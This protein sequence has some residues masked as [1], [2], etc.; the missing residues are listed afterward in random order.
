[1]NITDVRIRKINSSG[2][3]R[4]VVSV[5]M[6]NVFVVHEIKIVEGYN[7]LFVAM[8]SRKTPDGAFIDVAHPIDSKT[9]EY[10]QSLVLE[11][12]E[13]MLELEQGKKD[14]RKVDSEFNKEA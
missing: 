9:R 6:D 14:K 11:R 3:L 7:G 10:L 12:Y 13:E 2:K 5:T 4:A 1:M 8:P